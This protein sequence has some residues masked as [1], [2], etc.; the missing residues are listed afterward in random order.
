MTVPGS[1]KALTSCGRSSLL[2]LSGVMPGSRLGGKMP[3]WLPQGPLPRVLVPRLRGA[4]APSTRGGASS[5]G[6][7]SSGQ[8]L[9]DPAD[10]TCDAGVDAKVVG[11]AAAQAPAD[12]PR[13][14][15]AA[16]GLPAHQRAA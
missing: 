9:L 4:L 15:P 3:L 2:V 10:H 6:G 11:P 13:Q 8:H 16:T 5:A 7:S 12:Q 14:E 1:R